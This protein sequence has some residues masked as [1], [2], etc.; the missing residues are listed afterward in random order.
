MASE[1]PRRAA[2]PASEKVKHDEPERIQKLLARAGIGSRREIEGWMEA[3]RLIVNGQPAAPGQKAT[4][5]DRFELDGKRLDVSGAA[6]VLRRVLIYNKPE[7]EVTT[8][9]D[10]EGR[11]TVFDRLPRLKD[12]RWISIGRLDINTTGL[13]LFTTDGEL[14]NRLMHPSSQIDREYAVRIFGEVDD[15]MIG[16]LMEGVLLED[17]IAKF[18]DLSPAG[19]SGIN[20]WFHVTL[21]EGRNRE[22]RRLWESQGVRVSRLKRVRYGP[23][24]LPSR[25]TL[26]K[27]E[28]LDQKAVDLLSRTVGLA[29]KDIPQKTPDEKA[30]QDR[31]RRKSPGRTGKKPGAKRWQVSDSGPAKT[32]GKGSGTRGRSA[33]K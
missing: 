8:R 10:P 23:V 32:S 19:G 9:K 11:P 2:K 4:V 6:E 28:E 20:R 12:H 31:Q 15:A 24:F 3:G 33:R 5:E 27:W 21:L 13:V 26:G 1:R 7:G 25:L 14:A 30:A 16:R 29:A 17:G 18:T 22:V